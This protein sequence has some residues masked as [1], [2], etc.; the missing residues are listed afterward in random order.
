MGIVGSKHGGDMT[1]DMVG[2]EHCR[3]TSTGTAGGQD[4]VGTQV[5]V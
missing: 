5:Q 1:M 3:D 2:S 4:F